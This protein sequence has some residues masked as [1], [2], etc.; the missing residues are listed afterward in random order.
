MSFPML[1]FMPGLP[2]L[3]Q[4][5]VRN[6]LI[7]PPVAVPIMVA[8]MS[9]P[10]WVYIIVKARNMA[11]I[12]PPPV[13]IMRPIPATFPWTPPPAVPE[14]QINVYIRSNV[15]VVRIRERYYRWRCRKCDERGQRNVNSNFHR[16]HRWHRTGNYQHK[17]HCSQKYLLHFSFPFLVSSLL[18]SVFG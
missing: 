13:I 4:S 1:I 16:C 12:N 6:P 18:V 8:V 9:S 15:H 5:F 17:K 3:L 2:V 14:K 11:V 10:A 7:V